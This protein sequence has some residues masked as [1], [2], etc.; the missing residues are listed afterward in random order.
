[1]SPQRSDL[2]CPRRHGA[3][4]Q[5][6]GSCCFSVWAP[7]LE[8]LE[9][10]L[11]SPRP[12][13]IPFERDAEGWHQVVVHG[14]PAGVEYLL[15]LPDGSELP[16]PASRLQADSVH[17]PSV[18]VDPTHPWTDAAW[19]A[20]ALAEFVIQELHVGTFTDDGTFDAVVPKLAMLRELGITAIE[21]MPIAQFPGRRNWGYDGVLPFA[22]Q[23]SYGGPTSLRRLVDACHAAGIA[24]LVDVVYNH[25]GPE[26]NYLARFGPYFT[27][28]YRTPWGSALNFD[29]PHSD[30]VRWFFIDSALRLL[31]EFHVDG[32][33]VDAVHAIYDASA[34]P[35][36]Q[37]LTA[38]LH[39]RAAALRRRFVVIAESDLND[40]RVLHPPLLGG[41][42]MDAQWSDDFHHA[43]HA[44]VTG[45][46]EG[47]YADFG[48]LRALATAYREGW[49][50]QGQHSRYRERRHGNSPQLCRP[51]Q[52]VVCTQNHDQI[53]NRARGDRLAARGDFREQRLLAAALLLAPFVPMLFMGQEYGETAPFPYFTSHEDPALIEAVRRGRLAEFTAFG[54]DA[55][56]VPDPQ[57]PATFASARLDRRLAHEPVHAGLLALHHELLRLRRT[58]PALRT[59]EGAWLDVIPQETARQLIVRRACEGQE[60]LFVLTFGARPTEVELPPGDWGLLLD[61]EDPRWRGESAG[62][63]PVLPAAMAPRSCRL[64]E[65]RLEPLEEL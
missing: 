54:W 56:E 26:G 3:V 43:L 59:R 34:Q 57:D 12:A 2:H 15:R 33:R 45:E 8:Q 27:D 1:M 7:A 32:L 46:R 50:F 16:D 24:V 62:D 44:L 6:D 36:L 55:A 49:T 38:T 51:E 63:A 20:P 30:E 39:A 60:L 48:S 4:L 14:I 42:G 13:K 40:A 23:N 22:V 61:T 37:E 35:F 58:A 52:F 65:R 17:G 29:G 25:L 9:L 21:L 41:L 31:E 47:Y 5:P 28:H 19:H 64:W 10:R 18:V 11:V 53:G